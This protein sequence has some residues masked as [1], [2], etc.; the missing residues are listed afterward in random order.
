MTTIQDSADKNAFAEA[1]IAFSLATTTAILI[2]L[3]NLFGLDLDQDESFY[4]KNISFFVLP[5]LT[6][7][8]VWKRKL[9][10]LSCWLLHL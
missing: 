8:F 5:L 6:G 3:P 10:C 1:I 7:Y 4:I 2:K 9:A